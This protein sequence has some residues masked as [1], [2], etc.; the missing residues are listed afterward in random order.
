MASARR[1]CSAGA[2]GVC[3]GSLRTRSTR[4]HTHPR[5]QCHTPS[6]SLGCKERCIPAAYVTVMIVLVTALLSRS[7]CQDASG[8]PV[9]PD[10]G[11]MWTGYLESGHLMSVLPRASEGWHEGATGRKS[12]QGLTLSRQRLRSLRRKQIASAGGPHESGATAAEARFMT[13]EE[14]NW[15][16]RLER[17]GVGG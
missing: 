14:R 10:A 3:E 9:Q 8:F 1:A 5:L 15:C 7:V 4:S 17:L 12:V 11:F 6:Q 13:S 2:K 16:H